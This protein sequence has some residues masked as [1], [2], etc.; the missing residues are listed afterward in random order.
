MISIFNL[1]VNKTFQF[2][3]LSSTLPLAS[4]TF[5]TNYI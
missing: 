1:I 3:Q 2:Y 4:D 5:E